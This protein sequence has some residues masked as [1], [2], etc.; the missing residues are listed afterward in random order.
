MSDRQKLSCLLDDLA[1]KQK[2]VTQCHDYYEALEKELEKKKKG[3]AN[4]EDYQELKRAIATLNREY[5]Q[6]SALLKEELS[7]ILV[8]GYDLSQTIGK[9]IAHDFKQLWDYMTQSQREV[10]LEHVLRDI[11]ALK[12]ELF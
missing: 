10:R 9:E 3:L 2:H 7:D 4:P 12:K 6:K 8:K 5:A 11:E 1:D